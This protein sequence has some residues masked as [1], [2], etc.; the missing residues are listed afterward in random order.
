MRSASKRARAVAGALAALLTSA[1]SRAPAHA[2][3]R[4]VVRGRYTTGLRVESCDPNTGRCRLLWAY[5]RL[6]AR[7]IVSA[8]AAPSGRFFYVWS[9]IARRSRELDVF[10]FASPGAMLVGRWTPGYGGELRWVAGEHLWHS[11]GCGTSCVSAALYDTRGRTVFS[12]VG[13]A[14]WRSPDERF[15]IA[16]DYGGVATLL[17]FATA[18]TRSSAP[19]SGASFPTGVTWRATHALVSFDRGGRDVVVRVPFP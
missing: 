1:L 11:W 14:L 12:T 19:V 7:G 5:P 3:E 17:E 13:S 2:V 4:V 8:T 6:P 15:A 10:E 18:R 16:A 9:S